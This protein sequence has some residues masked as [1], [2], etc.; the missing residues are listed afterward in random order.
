[1]EAEREWG[2]RLRSGDR[3]ALGL[4]MDAYGGEVYRTALLLLRDKHTSEDMAQEVF[5]TVYR[6]IGQLRDPD[7]LRPWMISITVNLCRAY[8]RK[9][10]WKR[11]ILLTPRQGGSLPEAVEES[12]VDRI[13]LR[14]SLEKCIGQLSYPYREVVVLHYFHDKS[15]AEMSD[16]LGTSEGTIKSRLS[17]AREHMLL[18]WKEGEKDDTTG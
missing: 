5:L 4:L 17:R 3:E 16:M 15:V 7:C 11:L 14:I 18:L 13:A 9:A 8:M 2:E 10:A 1:M 6:K 12:Q